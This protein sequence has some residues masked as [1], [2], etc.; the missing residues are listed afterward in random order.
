[1]AKQLRIAERLL[2]GLALIEEILGFGY[3]L[4]KRLRGEALGFW[5]PPEYPKSPLKQALNRLLK[6]DF[7]ERRLIK[8]EPQLVIS[9]QGRFKLERKFSFFKFQE[10]KWDGYWRLVIFDIK[11][12]DR[13]KRRQLRGKLKEL[14]FGMWQKSIYIS[15]HDLAEDMN[16]FLQTE[17]L[18]GRAYVLTAKHYLLG[19]AKNLAEEVWHLDKLNEAYQKISE[20]ICRLAGL[21]E[22]KRLTEIKKICYDYGVMLTV[23]PCLPKQLLP[24]YWLG[25]RVRE[26]VVKLMKYHIKYL[27]D[28]TS[29]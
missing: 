21:A 11:E 23:D 26:E 24:D 5:T 6:A 25:N 20:K 17:N 8:G 18:L 29:R 13:F 10:K 22:K 4:D 15:P 16:E 2:L 7:L 28:R 9:N 14:G 12:K 1:M 27:A 19:E 3:R